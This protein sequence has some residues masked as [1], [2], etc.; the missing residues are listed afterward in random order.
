MCLMRTAELT[1]S[2]QGMVID[3]LVEQVPRILRSGL[4]EE[5][6]LRA[7]GA[8]VV[9]NITDVLSPRYSFSHRVEPSILP[10]HDDTTIMR[11]AQWQKK[12]RESGMSPEQQALSMDQLEHHELYLQSQERTPVSQPKHD[13]AECSVDIGGDFE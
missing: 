4:T 7:M 10:K 11:L 5:Q 2:Q 6:K 13:E 12:L 9:G 3:R 8:H 1:E